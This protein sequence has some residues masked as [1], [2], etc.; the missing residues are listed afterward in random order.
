MNQRNSSCPRSPMRITKTEPGC[1]AG[2]WVSG[3]GGDRGS[4]PTVLQLQQHSALI[5]PKPGPAE[6][7]RHSLPCCS[8]RALREAVCSQSRVLRLLEDFKCRQDTCAPQH[9]TTAAP[10]L[11]L[12]RVLP[13]RVSLS[14]R[15]GDH[16]APGHV[17]H[18]KPML[19]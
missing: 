19:G 10:H 18:P 6:T 11:S 14:Q 9:R 5:T 17:G 3:Q 4:F 15:V 12:H 16:C 1:T 13:G 2:S 8:R 7:R